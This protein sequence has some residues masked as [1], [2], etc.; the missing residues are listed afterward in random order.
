MTMLPLALVFERALPF[1]LFALYL[2]T[3]VKICRYTA[4]RAKGAPN[5]FLPRGLKSAV[6]DFERRARLQATLT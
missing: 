6:R 2:I 3:S 5:P 4:W 1:L